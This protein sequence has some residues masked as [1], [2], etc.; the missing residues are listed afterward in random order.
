MIL[1]SK[2]KSLFVQGFK[3]TISHVFDKW[4][5]QKFYQKLKKKLIHEIQNN[6]D[7]I[8]NLSWQ[9]Q[10]SKSKLKVG[11]WMVYW[12]NEFLKNVGGYYMEGQKQGLWKDLF[13]NYC[14]QNLAFEIGEY[15][16]D[17]RIGNW[18]YIWLENKICGGL[19]NK[20]GQKQG[21][22]VEFDKRFGINRQ[23]LYKG[24]YNFQGI[25]IGRWDIMYKCCEYF[26]NEDEEYKQIGGGIYGLGDGQIKIGRWIDLW[27]NFEIK[28]EITLNGVYNMKGMKVGK[29]SIACKKKQMQKLDDGGGIYGEGE[30]EIKI[31]RWI[32]QWENFGW[33]R[34]VTF[35]GEYN[36]KGMKIGRWDIWF[37]WFSGFSKKKFICGGGSYGEGQIKIGRW[38]D[39][40]ENFGQH[41]VVTCLGEYN[42]KGEK[43]GR[44]DI[45][46]RGKQMCILQYFSGGG[47]YAEGEDQIKIGKWVEVEIFQDFRGSNFITYNGEYN[48]KG[49]KIG[50]WVQ[51]GEKKDEMEIQYLKKNKINL[52]K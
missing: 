49:I 45:I 2:K 26:E 13:L 1:H 44:W 34:E 36:M 38:V 29:W 31:G 41:R 18:N 52:N 15:E 22:W 42:M 19:Y 4:K 9:G 7:Q 14:D 47:S 33:D 39:L 6:M 32:E 3:K 25:K 27:D 40:W 43:V 20:Y 23:V 24:E 50:T 17:L 48:M 16:N 5:M 35:E 51:N 12:N 10:Y 28:R 37:V 30:G 21:K 46:H 11:K 8:Q